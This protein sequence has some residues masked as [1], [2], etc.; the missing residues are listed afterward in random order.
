MNKAVLSAI[1]GEKGIKMIREINGKFFEDVN[2]NSKLGQ[3]IILQYNSNRTKSF[4]ELYKNPS[5][6]KKAIQ[7]DWKRFFGD[8]VSEKYMGNCYTFSIYAKVF[9]DEVYFLITPTHN[10]IV[11]A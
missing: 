4:G 11:I 5:N 7:R 6:E 10:Y 3:S 9:E 8:F 2:R 1:R